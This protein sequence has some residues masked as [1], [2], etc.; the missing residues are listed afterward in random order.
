[1]H[2]HLHIHE[3]LCSVYSTSDVNVVVNQTVV[4]DPILNYFKNL[5]VSLINHYLSTH[6][7]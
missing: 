2:T 3:E 5:I 6:V 1:M 7:M 4:Y